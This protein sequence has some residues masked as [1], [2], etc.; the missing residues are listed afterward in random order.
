M[1]TLSEVC[2]LVVYNMQ[3][4]SLSL[5]GKMQ[6][7]VEPL[8][9]TSLLLPS[10][11]LSRTT[12]FCAYHSP[13]PVHCCRCPGHPESGRSPT[14]D[15]RQQLITRNASSFLLPF[16]RCA[17]HPQLG[18][19]QAGL[20]GL[21]SCHRQVHHRGEL[22]LCL[23][24]TL[25]WQLPAACMLSH[26][27]SCCRGSPPTHPPTLTFTPLFVLPLQI[28]NFFVTFVAPCTPAECLV[29]GYTLE[30]GE[31]LGLGHRR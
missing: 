11:C 25:R 20:G 13:I 21:R 15:N 10:F 17:G 6:A 14:V 5:L 7:R 22:L 23:L 24:S 27:R 4:L 26:C 8:C 16:C 12:Y 28:K 1:D 9:P 30:E 18:R 3:V 29:E 19:G 2:T 31:T